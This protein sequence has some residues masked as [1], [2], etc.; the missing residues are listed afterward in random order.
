MVNLLVYAT[1]FLD[2]QNSIS[3]QRQ[4][5]SRHILTAFRYSNSS[6]PF[7]FINLGFGA[8]Q[9][10]SFMNTH[11][12]KI[13]SKLNVLARSRGVKDVFVDLLDLAIFP[14][15]VNDQAKLCRNPLPMYNEEEQKILIDVLK[16]LGDSMEDYCD[17]LG[18]FFMEFLSFGKNGQF[19]T[20]QPICD[21]M[22]QMV[23]SD[24]DFPTD[25]I[26][27]VCDCACGSGRTLLAAAKINRNQ[28]FYGSDVD[29][30]CVKMTVINMAYNSLKGEIHWMNTLSMDHYGTFAIHVEPFTR[31]PYIITLAADKSVSVKHIKEAASNM[32]E[33]QKAHVANQVQQLNLFD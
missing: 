1:L 20:P 31:V 14:L 2:L 29:I 26:P 11:F 33:H 8:N 32:P 6:L 5:F 16:V 7:A 17:G 3:R 4:G 22:A 9:K 18:D 10:K 21:M 12:K 23:Y 19:F 30:T 15:V 27:S 28:L 13:E 25:H 24:R